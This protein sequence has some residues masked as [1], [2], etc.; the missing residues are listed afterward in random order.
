MINSKLRIVV[1]DDEPIIRMDLKAM[2]KN[3]GYDVVGEGGDG[4]D[5]ID[6]CKSLRPDVA[7][8]DIK[9]ELLDGLSA[10]QVISEE[11]PDT[12][13]IMLTAFSK[14]EYI[15]KA[16]E[17]NISS[18]LMKPINEKLLIP[19][20]ELAVARNKERLEYIHGI[21]RANEM[22][23]SR[24]IIEKAKGLIMVNRGLKEEEAYCYIRNIS[25]NRNIS[26]HKVAEIIIKQYEG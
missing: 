20:V 15:D 26:M 16:K 17:S 18:Y 4:F 13:I 11:C 23:E 3:A 9:M 12:A 10:A 21:D 6:L 14:G 19:N 2:L 1:I 5:A 24:K 22:L 7:I 25:K 8:L